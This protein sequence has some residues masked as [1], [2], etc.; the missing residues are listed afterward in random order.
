[1]KFAIAV[2]MVLVASQAMAQD[3]PIQGV[4]GDAAG[5]SSVAGKPLTTDSLFILTPDRIERYESS[6]QINRIM[7]DGGQ[8]VEIVVACAGEGETWTQSYLLAPLAGKD[9]YVIG[10]A[11]YPDVRHEV[12]RCE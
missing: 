3:N 7:V 10:P 11:D 4:Y 5:C 8:P 2:F 1:M 6:C 9:G 12:R